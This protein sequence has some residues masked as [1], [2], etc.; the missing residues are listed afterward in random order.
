MMGRPFLPPPPFAPEW[1][2]GVPVGIICPYAGQLDDPFSDKQGEGE[3]L[4]NQPALWLENCGWMLCDGRELR[5]VNCPE[6]F[7]VIGNLYG[8]DGEYTFWLPDYRGLFLRCVDDGAKVDPDAGQRK[9]PTDD[10]VDYSGVGSK[11]SDALENHQHRY[12]FADQG[13]DKTT[14]Q[15]GKPKLP[16]KPTATGEPILPGSLTPINPDGKPAHKSVETRPK[17]IYVNYIIKFR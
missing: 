11:Q 17:N 16:S 7:C 12:L 6:L 10:Q 13:T 5:V 8:G 4:A 2:G 9:L 1:V 15:P 14:Y 3:S